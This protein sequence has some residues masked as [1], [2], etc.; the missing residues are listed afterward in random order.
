MTHRMQAKILHHFIGLLFMLLFLAACGGGGSGGGGGYAEGPKDKPTSV[1]EPEPVLID[2]ITPDDVW[3]DGSSLVIGHLFAKFDEATQSGFNAG[4]YTVMAKN[5]AGYVKV[6]TDRDSNGWIDLT[7]L[8]SNE[9]P[10]IMRFKVDVYET[11]GVDEESNTKKYVTYFPGGEEYGELYRQDTNGD[12]VMCVRRSG[13]GFFSFCDKSMIVEPI[14]EI[15]NV[16][17]TDSSTLSIRGF[18]AKFDEETQTGLGNHGLIARAKRVQGGYETYSNVDIDEQGSGR[19]NL[20]TLFENEPAG[21][22]QFKIDV[23]DDSFN[24]VTWFPGGEEYGEL[25]RLDT[26]GEWNATVIKTENGTYEFASPYGLVQ[27]E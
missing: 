19:I 9:A 23:Y 22:K 6:N 4:T 14:A 21:V 26:N 7:A 1:V 13:D 20:A 18:V 5:I 12:W 8:F 27:V 16:S 17:I 25:Y 11:P 2:S 3:F 10:G 24:Y 15:V